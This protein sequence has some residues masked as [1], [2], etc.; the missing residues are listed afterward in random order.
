MADTQN[1][2]WL[3]TW[4]PSSLAGLSQQMFE[5]EERGQELTLDLSDL[6]L[7]GDATP[8]AVRLNIPA[9]LVLS[10][11]LVGRFRTLPVSVRLPGSRGLNLQLARGGVFFALSNRDAVS[12]TDG[13][14][15]SWERV[16]DA[17]VQPFHPNDVD[18]YREALVAKPDLARDEWVVRA[19]FQRYLLSVVHP[20]RRP[21]SSLREDLQRIARRWLSGRLHVSQGSDLVATLLD[22]AEVFYEI[23]VNVPDHA[24]LG[25]REGGASLGQLYATLGGGRDSHNR[26]HFSVMDNGVGLPH[27]VN[28]RFTDKHRTADEALVDSVTGRLPRRTGGR[29]V[30]LHRVHQIAEQ[31]AAGMR[32]VGGASSMRII[33]NADTEGDAVDLDWASGED[34]PATKAL[35]GVPVQGTLV[36]IG[37]GLERRTELSDL[38]DQLE[39]KFVEPEAAPAPA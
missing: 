32:E 17:W 8:S 35:P 5:A 9:A 33:T 26:L 24:G 4:D 28:E 25:A 11:L 15:P 3:T 7:A 21:A 34:E 22:C 36:W 38:A 20:H 39:L 18:M 37:L 16:A 19:A 29:G 23:V 27:R 30:G 6:S 12:W 14:P 10:N 31:Y 13:A 2:R 1:M